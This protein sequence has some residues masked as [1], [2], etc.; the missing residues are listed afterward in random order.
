MSYISTKMNNLQVASDAQNRVTK[1]VDD[2]HILESSKN[3][4]K[5]T[6]DDFI[7][8]NVA[9]LQKNNNI[10]F[11]GGKN[12]W[13]LSLIVESMKNDGETKDQAWLKNV[14]TSS[15][16]KDISSSINET[17]TTESDTSPSATSPSDNKTSANIPASSENTTTAQNTEISTPQAS[18][19]TQVNPD[20][21]STAASEVKTQIP[22]QTK[23]TPSSTKPEATS[24]TN[25]K[26]TTDNSSA[27]TNSS[28]TKNIDQ[29]KTSEALTSAKL[30]ESLKERGLTLKN[31]VV[32]DENGKVTDG[33]K[34]DELRG[35]PKKDHVASLIKVPLALALDKMVEDGKITL[36]NDS[37]ADLAKMLKISSN[38]AYNNL[39]DVV[40][41]QTGANP[42]EKINT[43]LKNMGYEDIQVNSKI[44]LTSEKNVKNRN[45]NGQKNQASASELAKAFHQLQNLNTEVG[46][47][48]QKAGQAETSSTEIEFLSPLKALSPKSSKYGLLNGLVATAMTL[49][50]G[51]TIVVYAEHQESKNDPQGA[52]KAYGNLTNSLQESFS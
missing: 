30:N 29:N 44:A 31:F 35:G 23:K 24:T 45:N 42:Y 28:T 14:D 6:K 18:T 32:L 41:E 39:I 49:P 7:K 2:S 26:T 34:A 11:S 10:D 13:V 46:N 40:A 9:K 37:K 8:T 22:T 12:T 36:N 52:K 19:Q 51:K 20:A 15:I 25:Q 5:Q 16:V 43:T 4:P 48:A 38:D 21:N 1:F 17:S 27:T 33:H 47:I 3:K 50:D